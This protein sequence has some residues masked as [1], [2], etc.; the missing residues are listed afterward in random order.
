MEMSRP[1]ESNE[2]SV[3]SV[4]A[5]LQAAAMHVGQ[6]VAHHE[7][8]VP[9]A[10]RHFAENEKDRKQKNQENGYRPFPEES[11]RELFHPLKSASSQDWS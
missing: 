8:C 7:V 4:V 3:G 9:G 1:I 2:A 6:S 10:A 5:N 11:H